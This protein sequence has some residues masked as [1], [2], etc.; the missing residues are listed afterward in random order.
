VRGFFDAINFFMAV[1]VIVTK[2]PF[3]GGN[4]ENR[5]SCREASY[6]I[7]GHGYAVCRESS[8]YAIRVGVLKIRA[9]FSEERDV[10]A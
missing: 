10:P 3:V 8:T 6:Y 4:K 9:Y 5:R 2:F 1:F 7:S